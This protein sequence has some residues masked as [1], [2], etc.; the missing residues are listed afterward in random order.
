[1]AADSQRNEQLKGHI[2]QTVPEAS[3]FIGKRSQGEISNYYLGDPITDD[4]VAA[5]Q[6]AAEKLNVDVLNTR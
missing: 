6:A 4:E 1:M 3:I 2:Y 5:I